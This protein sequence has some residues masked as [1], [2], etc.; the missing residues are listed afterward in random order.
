MFGHSKCCIMQT[1]K[2]I[3]LYKQLNYRQVGDLDIALYEA[4]PLNAPLALLVHGFP[5]TPRTWRHLAPM[6]LAAGYRV[7][8]PY[9]R[10]A[11]P[12]RAH[13]GGRAG[14]DVLG[15]DANGLHDVLGGDTRA[16]IIGH[17]W[18]A[19]A[20]HAA[21]IAAPERWSRCV[22]LSW[23]PF[24][25]DIDTAS[26]AQ[27]KRSWYVFLLQLPI[28]ESVLTADDFALVDQ[29]WRDWSPSFE[30]RT[31]A[32]FAKATLRDPAARAT[33]I[34]HYRALYAQVAVD[35]QPRGF[36]ATPLLYLHGRQDGCINV[37]FAE[38]L[39][40]HLP[41]ALVAIIEDA[42]HFPQLEQAEAVADVTLKF[43]ALQLSQRTSSQKIRSSA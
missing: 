37:G 10:G 16:V 27:M 41:D 15:A 42:G 11:A 23:P 25:V 38:S 18:G 36:P 19:A 40:Q 1:A 14:P 8:M 3:D 28:A 5:D 2:Y 43:T 29:L 39:A 35:A 33:M 17:D 32:A 34:A 26:Y 30:G 4:G 6:L 7:A 31:D 21:V 24:P 12:T 22:S 9:I 20:A 13:D